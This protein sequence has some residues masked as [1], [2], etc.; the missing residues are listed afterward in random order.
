MK[1]SIKV[2]F[3]IFL[4]VLLLSTVSILSILVLQGIR[5]NQE[6]QYEDYLIQQGQIASNYTRQIYLMGTVKDSGEF[7]R[8]HADELV[9]QF[10][11]MSGMQAVLFDMKGKEVADSRPAA[12][13]TN[14]SGLIQ[15]ALQGKIAY[16]EEANN[17]LF[18]SPLRNSG[19][20]IGV[21]GFSYPLEK[22]KSFYAKIKYLFLSVGIFVFVLCFIWGY[23]YVLPLTQGISKLKNTARR[24]AEGDFEEIAQLKRNDELGELSRDISYMGTRIKQNVAD[25]TEEQNKLKLAVEKLE[26]LGK[27]QKQFI[28][29]VTHEFRTPLTVI[30]AYTDLMDMYRD[31]P[32]LLNSSKENIDKEI[33]RLSEM[34][35]KVL[36]L[37]SLEKYDFELRK[38]ELDI[39]DVLNDICERMKGKA[40]KFGLHLH[41]DLEHHKVVADKEI[42]MQIFINLLDNAIK[43]NRPDGEIWVSSRVGEGFM[44]VVVKDTGIGIPQD[45]K[46][47]IFEPFFTV[48]KDRSRRSGSTGLGLSLVK[49][50]VDRQGGSILLLNAEEGTAFEIKLPL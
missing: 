42:L 13:K 49:E 16:M 11:L 38:E 19:E 43:Y 1:T 40:Q 27:Q 46:E 34:V 5:K 7:L 25:M 41:T 26:I 14:V 3:G 39:Y 29:N 47:K 44:T 8:G 4:A 37:S 45:A 2:K 28:G 35:E 33:Q 24:I 22:E 15:Y 9:K 6:K 10:E 21:T 23:L 48:S 12:G 30:K 18:L 31:D 50:L 17:I 20:Q 36:A 32:E